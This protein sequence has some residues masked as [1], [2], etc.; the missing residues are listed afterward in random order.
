MSSG[1]VGDDRVVA[2]PASE[3]TPEERARR[4]KIEVERLARL[5]TVEW[6]FYASL[7]DHV[8]QFGVTTDQMRELVE[9]VLKEKQKTEREAKAEEDRRKQRIEKQR[10]NEQREEDRK[11][12]EQDRA[13]ERA[14][15][16]AAK[17]EREKEKAF[18][19]L[20]KLPK[21][22]HGKRLIELARRLDE[23]IELL[24][25]EFK[26]FADS[27]EEEPDIGDVE[28]WPDP[29]DTKALLNELMTQLKRYVVVHDDASVA[30]VLW[31]MFAWVHNI[32]VH[33]PYLVFVSAEGD[34]GKT[35]ACDV[36][37]F[38]S[39]RGHSG[40]ELTAASIYRFVDRVRPTLIIDDADTLFKRKPDLVTIVNAAWTRGTKIPR[41]GSGGLTY[42]F[43]P[44]S[45]KVIAGVKLALLR[46]TM[47][48]TISVKI[49]PKLPEEKVEDF[50]HVDDDTFL[51]L[52]RKLTRW[53][54]DNVE[55]LK[56]ARPVLPPGFTNRLRMNWLLQLAIAD[57]AG[58]DWPKLARR[59]AIRLAR[60]RREPSVGIR[61]LEMF[62][63]LFA[64]HG[65]EITSADVQRWF[66]ADQDDEWAEFNGPGRPITKRQIALLIAD[67]GINPGVIHPRGSKADRGY[68]EEWFA[69]AF[70]R[71]LK[72]TPRKRTTV[73]KP[74][75]KLRK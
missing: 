17:K 35:T 74:C 10:A 52:R 53:A 61:G 59:A 45:P 56:G 43:D 33:S 32:A 44:F 24:K 65:T 28:L 57:L 2:F 48:R 9:A 19:A 73:R 63:V 16:E 29:V 39:P 22:E 54:A 5:P 1:T 11:R 12:R 55:A 42:W 37:K 72:L 60:E 75:G 14:D 31:V 64:T 7:E 8:Q 36:V 69:D 71:Y 15:K 30:I 68:K 62:R 6:R 34:C 23:D 20:I 50:D 58:G 51:T 25:D 49:V 26:E 38:L 70:A 47:T 46:T 66:A 21:A 67:Y 4:L 41:Q 40:T 3:I 27:E 18:A 13:Q